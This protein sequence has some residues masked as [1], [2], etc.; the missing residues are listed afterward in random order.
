MNGSLFSERLLD[1]QKE[2]STNFQALCQKHNHQPIPGQLERL[3]TIFTQKSEEYRRYGTRAT[4][5]KA[6]GQAHKAGFFPSPGAPLDKTAELHRV[7]QPLLESGNRKWHKY[8][9]EKLQGNL[10]GHDVVYLTLNEGEERLASDEAAKLC[11]AKFFATVVTSNS[12]K[13]CI[14]VDLTNSTPG[15]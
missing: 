2:I 6:P 13:P 14:T 11:Q 15:T 10:K 12:K 5:E 3:V 7:S 4:E 8:K 9:P 1:I